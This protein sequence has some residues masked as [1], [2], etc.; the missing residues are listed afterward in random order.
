LLQNYF[1]YHESDHKSVERT[2]T[3]STRARWR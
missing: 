3:A 2:S 1:P